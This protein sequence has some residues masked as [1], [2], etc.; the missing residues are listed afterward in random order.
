MPCDTTD[1][2]SVR[3][4]AHKYQKHYWL[5]K[6]SN[7][8]REASR[9]LSLMSQLENNFFPTRIRILF[10]AVF[11]LSMILVA[12]AFNFRMRLILVDVKRLDDLGSVSKLNARDGARCGWLSSSR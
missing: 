2:D 3:N 8:L 7:S 10:A 9:T 11:I 12:I 5:N 1:E 4:I 6:N